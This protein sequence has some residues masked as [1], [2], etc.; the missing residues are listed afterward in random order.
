MGGETQIP[1]PRWSWARAVPLTL[2]AASGVAQLF[3]YYTQNPA[4]LTGIDLDFYRATPFWAEGAYQVGLVGMFF[5]CVAMFVR[6][7]W[8]RGLF[9]LSILGFLVHRA[10]LFLLSGLTHH[11]PSVAPVTLFLA[12]FLNVVAVWAVTRGIR[13]GW[14]R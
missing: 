8:S 5:G 4:E 7:R 1:P 12:V 11:L 13:N 3:P 9:A 6:H 2:L 10:W 14:V